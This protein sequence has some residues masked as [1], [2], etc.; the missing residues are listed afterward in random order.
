MENSE[1]F[2]HENK[3]LIPIV[4][5]NEFK[6]VVKRLRPAKMTTVLL[7]LYDEYIKKRKT[8]D[9]F[10]QYKENRFLSLARISQKEMV[11]ID[12]M[13]YQIIPKKFQDI[14]ISPVS[15]LGINKVLTNINQKNILSAVRNVEV[16]SAIAPILAIESAKRRQKN[17]Y[18]E[19]ENGCVYLCTSHRN[20]RA[21]LFDRDKNNASQK[22]TPHF[23]LFCFSS[24][25]YSLDNVEFSSKTLDAHLRI[26]LNFFR[27]A[28][29]SGNF[30][31]KNITVSISDISIIERLIKKN[32]VNRD[33]LKLETTNRHASIFKEVGL[34]VDDR[35][36]NI[37][38]LDHITDKHQELRFPFRN[39][40]IIEKTVIENLKND[41]KEVSF[42]Y[43]LSR[44][45]GIGYFNGVCFKIRA[46]NKMGEVYSLVD[47]GSYD[48]VSKFIP[49]KNERFFSTGFGSELFC[50][51]FKK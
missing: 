48:W 22:L 4:E 12:G 40:K 46:E 17:N 6:D 31:V 43:H 9:I 30:E 13:I 15:P 38:E 20:I 27:A 37:I 39:L 11:D 8:S 35:V 45:A 33:K 41:Y 42:D 29:Q 25:G 19:L 50:R 24:S 36:N 1:S 7:C 10:N 44:I 23:Q 3:P 32:K 49:N 34:K 5:N 14:I 51:F 28:N 18:S 2:L 47:G 21:Q 16:V 26:I